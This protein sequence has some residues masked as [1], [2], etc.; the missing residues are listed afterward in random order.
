MAVEDGKLTR[1]HREGSQIAHMR[2]NLLTT[3]EAQI[4]LMPINLLTK[5]EAQIAHKQYI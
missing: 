2:I 5:M 4:A 1:Y 3:M